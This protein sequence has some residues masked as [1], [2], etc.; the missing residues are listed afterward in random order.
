M[1]LLFASL[2]MPAVPPGLQTVTDEHLKGL[3]EQ[4]MRA[5]NGCR[6]AEAIVE[7]VRGKT[8]RFQDVSKRAYSCRVLQVYL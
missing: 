7:H 2:L 8:R 6:V 3:D 4:A 1:D 5:I